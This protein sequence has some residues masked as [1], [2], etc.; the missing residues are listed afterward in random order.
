MPQ[1]L[2][3]DLELVVEQSELS[4]SKFDLTYFFTESPSGLKGLIEYRTEL[5]SE[6]TIIRMIG[7][8]KE[9]L[10]SIVKMP[11]QKI[12][13]LQMLTIAERNQLL[14]E[15]N[16][17]TGEYSFEKS[18]VTLFED[19]VDKTPNNIAVI[20]KDEHLTYNQLNKTVKPIGPL[21]KAKRCSKWK[22]N[23]G[24][25][26]TFNGDDCIYFRNIKSG[27]SVYSHRS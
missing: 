18:I 22:V 1:L 14:N 6:E 27:G 11:E 16:D 3:E 19:Q 23:S 2:L 17:T 26:R 15:F 21:F 8:F 13:A 12:A 10:R 20:F 7:H 9:L 24:L 25:F 5:F 4:I